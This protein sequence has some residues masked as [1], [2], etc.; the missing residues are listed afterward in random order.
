ML[1][2]RETTTNIEAGNPESESLPSYTIA[3]GL[4]SY[5]EALEQLKK[6]KELGS[7]S[8]KSQGTAAKS[9]EGAAESTW[10]PRTPPTPVASLSVIDLFQRYRNGTPEAVISGK[11]S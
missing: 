9:E 10:V 1:D 11:P 3:S 2:T 4:P 7:S 6:V 5:E 8:T